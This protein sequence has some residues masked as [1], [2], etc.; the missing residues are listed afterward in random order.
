MIGDDLEAL[1]KLLDY[2]EA[3]AQEKKSKTATGVF[4]Q[5]TL[6]D[7]GHVSDVAPVE[8]S[9]SRTAVQEFCEKQRFEQKDG[10][11]VPK[12]EIL[13][14]QVVIHDRDH[15]QMMISRQFRRVMFFWV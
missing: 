11:I 7:M 14:K 2:S 13:Y 12:S 10:R 9:K 6:R 15:R 1:S 4:G 8:V 3:C 5:G